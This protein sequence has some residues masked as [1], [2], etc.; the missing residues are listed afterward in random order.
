VAWLLAVGPMP[1]G[2]GFLGL[3]PAS[4]SAGRVQTCAK[5]CITSVTPSAR[6]LSL[7]FDGPMHVRIFTPACNAGSV[8]VVD[9]YNDGDDLQN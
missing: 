5:A 4:T 1:R 2:I 9:H 8:D 3:G 6:A 7:S